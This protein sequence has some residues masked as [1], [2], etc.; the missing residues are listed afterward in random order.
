M[1]SQREILSITPLLFSL[2]TS[3][4]AGGAKLARLLPTSEE[5]IWARIQRSFHSTIKPAGIANP[6]YVGG[7]K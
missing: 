4:Q 3:D 5:P 6:A 1:I 7:D 2:M